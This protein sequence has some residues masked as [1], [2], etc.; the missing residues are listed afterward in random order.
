MSSIFDDI[1]S[2][3]E[4]DNHTNK[5]E[6]Q[7][8]EEEWLDSYLRGGVNCIETNDVSSF[9]NKVIE[10]TSSN[11][12]VIFEPLKLH[13]NRPI[14]LW[15][16]KDIVNLINAIQK[17]YK[18]SQVQNPKKPIVIIENMVDV[19]GQEDSYELLNILLHNW[20]NQY[21]EFNE[22]R[23]G[24][25]IIKPDDYSV[26]ITWNSVDSA[27]MK[28]LW[29]PSDGFAWCGNFDVNSEKSFYE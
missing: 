21:S 24:H 9:S 29:S 10:F 11:H 15:R 2:P 1:S 19:I 8:F 18:L 27:N 22:S 16:V 12:A 7:R 13:Q 23:I 4:I 17:L 25:F 6:K 14:F 20:K 26:L 5:L 28:Q 3:E